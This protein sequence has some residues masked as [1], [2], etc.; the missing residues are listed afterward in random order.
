MARKLRI[1]F[2]ALFFTGITLLFLDLTGVLHR[3]LG[4]MAEIQFFPAV[5][6]LSVVTVVLTALVTLCFGRVYCSVI[7]PLGIFQDIFSWIHGKTSKKNRYRFRHLKALN[8]LRYALLVIFIVFCALGVTSIAALIE[9]YSTYGRIVNEIFA[10]LYRGVNNLFAMAED[11]F[12]SYTFYNAEVWFKSAASLAAAVCTFLLLGFLSW[13]WGRIWCNTVCPVGAFLSLLSRYSLFAPVIDNRKCRNCRL[14]EKRCKASCISI[15]DHKID[16]SRC[17]VCLDCLEE[18]QHDALHYKFRYSGKKGTEATE[19]SEDKGRRDFIRTGAVAIGAAALGPIAGETYA[20]AGNLSEENAGGTGTRKPVKPAGAGSL[21]HFTDHCIACQ[22]CVGACPNNVLTPSKS[23]ATLM[24]PEMTFTRG[25]CRPEC[26]RC[27]NVCPTGA[28]SPVTREEKTA[29]SVGY[30]VV[31]YDLCIADR[32]EASC[33][34]CA[35]HCPAGAI[36]LVHKVPE[37]NE[38]A[39]I[40]AVNTEKCIG[41]G[42]CEYNCPAK[43]VKAIKVEGRDVHI[44]Q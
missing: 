9:P 26:T 42:A 30:A 37:D 15:D 24:Q 6:S 21:K 29:I 7:C 17:V 34:N 16:Y 39:R 35:R 18:C 27:S 40:P 25:Y 31:D 4:W 20:L 41:C 3:W 8:W 12:G 36:R 33:G 10:P 19:S 5:L 23:P 11:H 38:S 2:A 32:G 14:C 44:V 13:K 28:I 22:L 1:A 43:P